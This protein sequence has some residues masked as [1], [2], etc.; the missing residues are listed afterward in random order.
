MAQW[1]KNLPAIQETKETWVQS[2]EKEDSLEKEMVTHSSIP[3]WRIPWTQKLRRLQS[4][5]WQRLRQDWSNLAHMRP[6][7]QGF[8]LCKDLRRLCYHAAQMTLETQRKWSTS[9]GELEIPEIPPSWIHDSWL[10]I[11]VQAENYQLL[12]LTHRW[13]C[14]QPK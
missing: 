5:G 2:L 13:P 12:H 11:C 9:L 4:L 7:T 8:I 3:A 10:S 6:M 1:V 14:K